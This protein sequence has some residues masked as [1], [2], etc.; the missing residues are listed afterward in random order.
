MPILTKPG[1]SKLALMACLAFLAACDQ[2]RSGPGKEEIFAGSVMRQGNAFVV[3]VTPRVSQA[4]KATPALGFSHGLRSAALLGAD[5]IRSGDIVTLSVYENVT[6]GLLA[7]TETPGAILEELQVDSEGYIF[8]PY[9]GRIRAAGQTPDA[10]RRLLTRQLDEQTPDPQVIVRRVAGDGTTVSV[11]GA[12]TTQGVYP[13][14]RPTRT[15]TA[16][17]AQAG[18][19]N[20]RPEIAQVRVTRGR[21]QDTVW[22]QDLFD[23]PQLDI[24]LRGGDRVLVEADQRSFTAMGATGRT[25]RITFES[26]TVSAIEAL[27][28]V[29]GLDPSR[30]D[31]TGVFVFRD[32]PP[33]IANALLGRNDLIGDQRFVYVLDLTAPTGMFEARDFAIRDKDTVYVTEASAVGWSRTI[34]TLTGTLATA[35][36]VRRVLDDD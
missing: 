7:G 10:L 18:G 13:I 25:E 2:P 27:A 3:S 15:L 16:M 14:E 11:L 17:L 1:A 12:V 6:E 35:T 34:A 32:E 30:A 26:R 29:G 36:T 4:T 5:S 23:H 20:V 31:P 22:L 9:A 28:S 8:V 21:Q 19:V 24:A 33:E